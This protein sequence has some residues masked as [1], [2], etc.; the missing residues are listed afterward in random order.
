M[1]KNKALIYSQYSNAISEINPD[2]DIIERYAI[3][4]K[5][6]RLSLQGHRLAEKNCNGEIQYEDF[7]RLDNKMEMKAKKELAKISQELADNLETNGD[8][9]GI[10]L[11]LEY[12]FGKGLN[13]KLKNR[14]PEDFGGYIYF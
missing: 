11:K 13:R 7:E 6:H 9:R 2:L 8:P 10:Y 14:F 3:I 4:E 5:L 1:N 12:N